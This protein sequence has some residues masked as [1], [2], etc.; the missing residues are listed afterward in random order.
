MF[1]KRPTEG[2]TSSA[3]A[4]TVMPSV[5][6]QEEIE[7]LSGKGAY[8]RNWYMDLLQGS[9]LVVLRKH[10]H[11]QM[12]RGARRTPSGFGSKWAHQIHW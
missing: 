1:L 7:H 5:R 2:S 12:K 10:K 8:M 6:I 9:P 3:K 11:A 4:R